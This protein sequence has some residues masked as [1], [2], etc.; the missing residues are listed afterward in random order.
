MNFSSRR[1]DSPT[2]TSVIIARLFL[3]SSVLGRDILNAYKWT[4]QEDY[5]VLEKSP[6]VKIR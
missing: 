1:V 4:V 2:I 6:I 3:I 5:I